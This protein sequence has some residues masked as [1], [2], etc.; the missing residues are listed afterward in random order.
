MKNLINFIGEIAAMAL[1]FARQLSFDSYLSQGLLD[2]KHK[3]VALADKMDW[4][5]IHEELAP[6]YSRIG[7]Q[8]LPIRLMVGLHLL[9]HMEAMSDEQVADRIRGDLYWMHFCGVEAA[10]LKDRFAH[11]DSS[12]LTKFRNRIGYLFIG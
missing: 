5:K 6:F 9:K 10:D 4:A 1:I 8:A 11:L 12:S 7:R 2:P 3:L